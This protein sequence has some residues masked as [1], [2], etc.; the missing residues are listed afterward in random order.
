MSSAALAGGCGSYDGASVPMITYS[1]QRINLGHIHA[2]DVR[3]EDVAHALSLICR[4]GGH[5]RHF[6][7]VAQH[8]LNCLYEA[9]ARGHRRE[10][11]LA[12]LLHD[13][14]E[15]YLSDVIRPVK[16]LLPD[17]RQLEKR[18]EEAVHMAFGLDALTECEWSDVRAVDDVML[19]NEFLLLRDDLV[20]FS[21][22]PLCLCPP[23]VRE[24]P[25]HIVRA[26][27][28]EQFSGL[29]KHGNPV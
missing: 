28:L 7:S 6:Y 15:A 23:D 13:A 10:V 27:F 17:Y 29:Q 3:V 11:Q 2:D 8:S 12:C 24:Q 1:G 19:H 25:P 21:E 9:K 20:V 14:G 18:V 26:L 4:A 16:A 5:I 22:P